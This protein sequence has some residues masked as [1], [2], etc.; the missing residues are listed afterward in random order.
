MV[1]RD[2]SSGMKQGK[3]YWLETPIATGPRVVDPCQ[4]A[5]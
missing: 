3:D 1:N 5:P 4:V 2:P